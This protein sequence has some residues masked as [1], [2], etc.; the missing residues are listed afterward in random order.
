M[1]VF[2]LERGYAQPYNLLNMI[3]TEPGMIMPMHG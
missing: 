1:F 2:G 3:Q